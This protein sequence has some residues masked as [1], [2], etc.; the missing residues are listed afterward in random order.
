M[1]VPH[2]EVRQNLRSLYEEDYIAFSSW[3]LCCP[4]EWHYI[5]KGSAIV[6]CKPEVSGAKAV[7]QLAI[8]SLA[9][10]CW[11][12]SI[13]LNHLLIS[14]K[15]NGLQYFEKRQIQCLKTVTRLQAH[16][17]H[18][19]LAS[20]HYWLYLCNCP[21]HHRSTSQ[22]CSVYNFIVVTWIW[23]VVFL[24]LLPD[25]I[26]AREKFLEITWVH[27]T[28]AYA[29]SA[30]LRPACLPQLTWTFPSSFTHC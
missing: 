26:T 14:S 16:S 13:H 19:L 30:S 1:S 29:I 15:P 18:I 21:F 28:S 6:Y 10:Y 5:Q 24:H 9:Q 20:F 12:I 2:S 27:S 8:S 11:A 25:G 17:F 22:W 23:Q 4:I 7:S 3:E